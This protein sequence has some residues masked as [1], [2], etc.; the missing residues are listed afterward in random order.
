VWTPTYGFL[1]SLAEHST[2]I[3]L[4]PARLFYAHFMQ[5]LFFHEGFG[6][7]Q[8]GEDHLRCSRL[9]SLGLRPVR[10]S[11]NLAW[12]YET[13]PDGEWDGKCKTRSDSK[14]NDS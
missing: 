1:H 8:S 7:P 11:A 14:Q 9:S 2:E 5:D 3:I 13:H 10:F 4:R 12:L 6:L